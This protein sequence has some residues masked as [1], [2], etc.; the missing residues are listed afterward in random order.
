VRN[1]VVDAGPMIGM[2]DRD[3]SHHKQAGAFLRGVGECRLITTSLVIGEVAA[4]LADVQPNLFRFMDWLSAAVEI[5]DALRED[6]PRMIEIMKKYD[7]LP[8]DLADVS[9]VALC[10]RRGVS[11]IA[12][13]D[14]D[15]EVYRLPKGRKF[16]NVFFNPGSA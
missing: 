10:E 7:D 8:A 14:S 13:V 3:D 9:L 2:F 15:F 12:S 11:T 6:L 4:M 1:I 16:E 5:D